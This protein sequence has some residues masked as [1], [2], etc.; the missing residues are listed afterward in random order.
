MHVYESHGNRTHIVEPRHSLV[1]GDPVSRM[2]MRIHSIS[3]SFIEG[4]DIV[5]MHTYVGRGL[6][7]SWN[8]RSY[9]LG[10]SCCVVYSSPRADLR[11]RAHKTHD[12]W[13]NTTWL[14]IA[15]IIVSRRNRMRKAELMIALSWSFSPARHWAGVRSPLR[16]PSASTTALIYSRS[17]ED[18]G[19]GG[20]AGGQASSPGGGLLHGGI[21]CK[22]RTTKCSASKPCV[23]HT[24]ARWG[25]GVSPTEEHRMR[26]CENTTCER[27][28][29][30]QPGLKTMMHAYSRTR[31]VV[32]SRTT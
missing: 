30:G 14:E 17:R 26:N 8:P 21:P 3:V 23:V 19:R 16:S 2:R 11:R 32:E 28:L 25:R 1:R 15:L 22:C 20:L 4:P 7:I 18:G 5:L 29:A 27:R 6:V 10:N 31:Q 12:E 13:R 9:S 24:C